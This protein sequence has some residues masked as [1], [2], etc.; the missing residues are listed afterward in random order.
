MYNGRSILAIIPAR[1]GSKGLP[2]KNVKDLAGKPLIAWTIREALKCG[3]IDRVIVT[4]DDKEIANI[5]ARYGAE[6]PFLRPKRLSLDR[7]ETIDVI[8]HAINWL[9]DEGCDYDVVVVL[10]P[11]SPLRVAGDIT[12]ALKMLFDRKAAGIVSVCKAEHNP[13]WANSIPVDLSMKDFL[14]KAVINKNRHKLPEFYRLNGAIYVALTEFLRSN[15]SFFGPGV[16]AYI[17]P[18]DR[19]VDID[20]AIDF[21]LAE[22]L[23]SE[24]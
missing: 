6:I 9:R 16:Y 19:S 3:C 2:R 15:R 20:D 4:T 11:T 13:L 8:L 7:T 5:S 23:I 18:K 14:P 10:Q 1:G 17:M 24:R 12:S 21:K 22:L